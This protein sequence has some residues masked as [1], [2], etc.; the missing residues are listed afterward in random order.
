MRSTLL[1]AA[2]LAA[3]LVGG[4]AEAR[5]E[6]R[7]VHVNTDAQGAPLALDVLGA[8]FTCNGCTAPRVRFG[9]VLL[10][11]R[12]VQVLSESELRIDVTGFDRGD[13]QL[14]IDVRPGDAE[15]NAAI[16]AVTLGASGP[17]GPAGPAGA[18][19]PQGPAGAAGAAGPAGPPGP[20]G[21]QGPRG[22]DGLVGP[23]GPQGLQGPAGPRGLTGAAGPVGPA[24]P[25]GPP[26]AAGADGSVGP[27][28]PQGPQ[29]AQGPAGPPGPA[30][31]AAARNTAIYI[32]H[33]NCEGAGALTTGAACIYPKP[34]TAP[35]CVE[36]PGLSC[37]AQCTG[38]FEYLGSEC[39][40]LRC[41]AFGCTCWATRTLN[42]GRC[43]CENTSIGFTVN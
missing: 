11:R 27:Q 37:A 35:R 30:G 12:S 38:S 29:G 8:G 1:A 2:A 24:G 18:P 19:G 31:S 10:P 43:N 17:A 3:A 16:F 9:G 22:A 14:R 28:G 32:V 39:S 33:P 41:N 6:I 23:A 4:V 36:D 26:G 42:C 5:P 20:V 13:Y 25:P 40:D 7:A 34:G 21:P 15:P